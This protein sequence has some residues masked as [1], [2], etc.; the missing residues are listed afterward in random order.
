MRKKEAFLLKRVPS[1]DYLGGGGLYFL[2]LSDDRPSVSL[3]PF[4]FVR[5]N[6]RYANKHTSSSKGK[7]LRGGMPA[8]ACLIIAASGGLQFRGLLVFSKLETSERERETKD[9]ITV[10]RE[11]IIYRDNARWNV[12]HQNVFYNR[13]Q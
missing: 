7:R 8:C 4:L 2:S 6:L 3:R 10:A 11:G 1:R 13:S 12:L 9:Q 5:V